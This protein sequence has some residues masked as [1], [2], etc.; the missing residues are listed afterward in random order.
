MDALE[1]RDVV[2]ALFHVRGSCRR[3]LQSFFSASF[4]LLNPKV[5]W[6]PITPNG[7]GNQ[8]RGLFLGARCVMIGDRMAAF[9]SH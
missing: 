8:S 2:S 9:S 5:G 7:I 6:L 4:R 1:R 3:E